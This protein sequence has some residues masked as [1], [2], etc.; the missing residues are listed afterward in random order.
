MLKSRRRVDSLLGEDFFDHSA[1]HVGEATF[2]S[3][4]IEAQAFVIEAQNVEN[5]G[6][7]IV[8]A[9]HSFHSFMAEFIRR[10][11]TERGFYAGSGQPGGEAIGVVIPSAGTFLEGW[12]PAKFGTENDKGVFEEAPGFEVF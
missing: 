1:V 6:V 3:I 2:D 4:V 10:S 8:N 5:G 12:H 7:E 11:V 9:G